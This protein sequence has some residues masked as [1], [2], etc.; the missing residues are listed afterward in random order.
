MQKQQEAKKDTCRAK[1][2]TGG[3]KIEGDL[4]QNQSDAYE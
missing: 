2:I 3:G 1:N 4:I